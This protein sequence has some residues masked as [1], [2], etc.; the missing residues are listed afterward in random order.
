MQGFKSYE[1]EDIAD[2]LRRRKRMGLNS[3]NATFDEKSIDRDISFLQQFVFD[4][5]GMSPMEFVHSLNYGYSTEQN[6]RDRRQRNIDYSR[7]RQFNE[8]VYDA[9]KHKTVSQYEYLKSRNI[10]PLSYNVI[11]KLIRSLTGQFREMNTGNIVIADSK[12]DMASELAGVLTS[13]VQRIKTNNKGKNKDA[14]NFKE[15]LLSGSPVFKVLWSSKNNSNRTDVS[16]RIVSRD[17][18][19]MNAG[20]TDYDLSNLHT[21]MEIH[22]SSL[23][24]ILVMF[25]NGDYDRG[26]QIRSGYIGYQG[27]VVQ[28][29]S[30]GNQSFDGSEKRNQSLHSQG[31]GQSSYRYY[32]VWKKISTYEAITYDPLDRLG[33]HK[34]HKYIDPKIIKKQV[35]A[36][37]ENRRIKSEG[38]VMDQDIYIKYKTDSVSRK[39]AIFMTPWGQ[40]LDVRESPFENGESPYCF[41]APDINGEVWGIVEEVLNAQQSLDRQIAQADAIVANAIKGMVWIPDT[42]VPDDMSNAEYI[43]KVKSVDGAAIYKVREGQ[44][45]IK[46]YQMYANSANVS[47]NVQQLISLYSGLVDEISGNY[48]AAQGQSSSGSTATGYAMETQNA[49][50]NVRDMMEEYQGMLVERDEKILRFVLQGYTS[51][52]YSRI[53]GKDVDAKAIKNFEFFIEQSKGTNSPAHRMALEQEL[54]QLVYNQLMPFEVFLEVSNN[55][56]MIQA[57]QKME[58][59]NKRQERG[60]ATL[61]DG[62]DN[63]Q[64]LTG[65]DMNPN[66]QMQTQVPGQQSLPKNLPR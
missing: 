6:L 7:G 17:D 53:T 27:D 44:E 5:I 59:M 3:V 37:N 22:K 19:W 41:L 33:T 56:M 50:L 51:A 45:D 21:E 61:Q 42:S 20:V 12:D 10:P 25:T 47:G 1:K 49:G 58:E 43:D 64:A 60:Q 13:C 40:V 16:F 24:D 54:L 66:Q 48:G 30:Y 65:G 18:F 32:E 15:M 39:Y 29:S 4:K 35:D 8:M 57:K 14:R 38:L 2:A 36:E 11:S 46:P 34:V 31:I 63:K 23:E 28:Q 52:D 55:P 26:M 62:V 9:Q